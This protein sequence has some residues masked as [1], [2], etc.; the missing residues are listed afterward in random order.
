MKYES[1]QIKN[2][3]Q[4]DQIITPVPGSW[5]GSIYFQTK[6][7]TTKPITSLKIDNQICIFLLDWGMDIM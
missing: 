3:N 4:I 7:K 1:H 5:K 6:N 2:N